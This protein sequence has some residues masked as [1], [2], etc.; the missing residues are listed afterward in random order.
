MIVITVVTADLFLDEE[1]INTKNVQTSCPTKIFTKSAMIFGSLQI[2]ATH[3][4]PDEKLKYAANVAAEWL[5]NDGDGDAD[6]PRILDSLKESQSLVVMSLDGFSSLAFLK[7]AAASV[8]GGYT[9]QDLSAEETNNPTRRDASQEEIHHIIVV[10]GWIKA[11]PKI[12]SD[13]KDDRS[14]LYNIWKFADDNGHYSY[15]DPTCDDSCKTV[16]FFYLAT[17]AYLG[18]MADLFSDEMRLKDK[19]AMRKHIPNIMDI[20]ESTDYSYPT[21]HWPTGVYTHKKNI[22]LSGIDSE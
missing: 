7:I 13:Q 10:G 9:I 22:Q 2:C 16:E 3:L 11:L 15:D 21:N 19:V 6:E 20:F 17:A 4:V 8:V 5:D 14:D 12:F 18:S 1:Y